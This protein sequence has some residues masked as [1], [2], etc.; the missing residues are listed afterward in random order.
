MK[1]SNKYGVYDKETGEL[2][3][4]DEF[5]VVTKTDF[6]NQALKDKRKAQYL[7][8]QKRKSISNYAHDNENFVFYLFSKYKVLDNLKPQNA[9]RLMYLATYMEYDTNCLQDDDL[10][11]LKKEDISEIMG[12]GKTAFSS[13]YKEVTQKKYLIACDDGRYKLN[14]KFFHKGQMNIKP[15]V[16]ERFTRVYINAMRKLYTSV[17]PKDHVYLGYILDMVPYINMQW[18][19]VCHNPL[20]QNE[21]DI[22][23]MTFGEFCDEIGYDK[24]NLYRLLKVYDRIKFEWNGKHQLFAAFIYDKN[25]ENMKIFINPHIFYAGENFDKIKCLGIFFKNEKEKEKDI[26]RDESI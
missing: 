24:K 25:K 20:E 18:N 12:L 9:I 17:D 7:Q 13:F 21:D 19:V 16:N 4:N 5:V 26:K 1:Y 10:R 6:E 15:L 14:P 8:A 11:K 22:I 2:I 3:D 23:P